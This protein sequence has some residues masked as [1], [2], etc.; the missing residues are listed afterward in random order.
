VDNGERWTYQFDALPS[1]AEQQA[2]MSAKEEKETTTQVG[3]LTDVELDDIAREER[4]TKRRKARAAA[5]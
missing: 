3:R 4:R 5:D 2:A 1:L